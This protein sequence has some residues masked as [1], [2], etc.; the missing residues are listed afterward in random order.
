M[1][2]SISYQVTKTSIDEIKETFL[3]ESG[4]ILREFLN[5]PL[6]LETKCSETHKAIN[7]F[8]SYWHDITR[9]ALISLACQA[10]DG[11]TRSVAGICKG[12]M[13]L[14]GGI[15]IHDDIIDRSSTKRDHSTVFG[16]HGMDVALI[17]GD[18]LFVRGLISIVENIPVE[19]VGY[20]AEA[21]RK[22]FFE[23]ADGEALELRFRRN[24]DVTPEEYL[25]I[26]KMKAADV[27][28]YTRIGAYIGG[29][30]K[31]E[32]KSL[33]RYGRRLGM[34]AILRDDLEDTLDFSGELL[35]RIRYECLPL[36]LIY[37]LQR[38]QFRFKLAPILDK[39]P[40]T[41][42]EKDGKLIL[43]IAVREENLACLGK[44]F[45]NLENEATYFVRN[46]RRKKGVFEQILKAT[47][48]PI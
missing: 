44:L 26:V 28:C 9:P 22:L 35:Y 46:L 25:R 18:R 13:L 33:G 24:W 16:V 32:V 6:D 4:N 41:L 1:L 39:D 30:S 21:V 34:L 37:A 10:V 2:K 45:R 48:P 20:T 7:L 36:P 40:S 31:E 38:P 27:E 23:L 12:L 11:D 42:D 8:K 5:D 47:V 15:D 3:R 17:T 29:G 19:K 14:S 43:N